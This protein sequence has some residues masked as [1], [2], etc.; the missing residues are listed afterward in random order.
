MVSIKRGVRR[1]LQHY[2][3]DVLRIPAVQA[4]RPVPAVPVVAPVDTDD[5]RRPLQRFRHFMPDLLASQGGSLKGRRILDIAC[6]SGF[7]SLQCALLGAEVAGF[8]ARPELIEQAN[9]PTC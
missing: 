7:W 3:Y 6:N 8:D 9:R 2:G 1:L 4:Q 5:P